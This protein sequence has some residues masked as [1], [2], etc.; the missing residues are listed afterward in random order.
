VT[1]RTTVRTAFFN[2]DNPFWLAVIF[3]PDSDRFEIGNVGR[4]ADIHI[5]APR[6]PHVI[7]QY[8]SKPHACP[9][10]IGIASGFCAEFAEWCG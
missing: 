5:L 8:F 2:W 6:A 1:H 10:A 3:L 9:Q 4:A 7:T